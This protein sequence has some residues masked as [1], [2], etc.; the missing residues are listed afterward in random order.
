MA[1]FFPP[2]VIYGHMKDYRV[3]LNICTTKGIFVLPHKHQ[4]Q[5][6]ETK[7]AQ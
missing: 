2:H 1:L 4:Y 7:N 6:M 3:R 5:L